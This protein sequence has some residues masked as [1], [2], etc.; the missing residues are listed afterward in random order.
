MY[1]RYSKISTPG[2]TGYGAYTLFSNL[3]SLQ[4]IHMW[5]CLPLRSKFIIHCSLMVFTIFF[6]LRLDGTI[7]WSYWAVFSPIWFWKFMVIVGATVGS[8]VWWRYPHFRYWRPP[9]DAYTYFSDI[10][11]HFHLV[12]IFFADWKEKRISI[13]KRC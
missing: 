12:V 10:V 9:D 13:T 2:T 4:L 3:V 6:S 1:K 5:F 8:Y 7:L 11:H